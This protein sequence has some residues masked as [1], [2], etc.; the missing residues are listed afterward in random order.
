MSKEKT[1]VIHNHGARVIA[2]SAGELEPKKSMKVPVEEAEKLQKLFAGE[3][4][5]VKEQVDGLDDEKK[6]LK[7]QIAE[8]EKKI[9]EISDE[10]AEELQ[11]ANEAL[12]EQVK[13]LES[14]KE[15]LSKE[16]A[17]LKEALDEATKPDADADAEGK[18]D[19]K[20]TK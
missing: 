17:E 16:V 18:A 8:L 3:I 20:K 11:K 4:S 13:E 15:A 7:A 9:S 10:G 12:T 14:E 6:D 2:C 19:A 1:T 5:D